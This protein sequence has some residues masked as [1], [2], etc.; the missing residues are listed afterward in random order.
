VD[1]MK[2][3]ILLLFTTLVFITLLSAKLMLDELN[4]PIQLEEDLVVD[5]LYGD[6]IYNVAE[7]LASNNVIVYRGLWVWYARIFG[8]AEKIKAGE[9]KIASGK[10]ALS[11]L[12]D[13]VKG[14]AVKYTLTIIEGWT[15][16]QAIRE[17]QKS[18]GIVATLD[19]KDQ[20]IIL[21]SINAE[22]QYSSSEG[23]FYPDTYQYTKGTKDREILQRAHDHLMV[24][25]NA[26]WERRAENLPYKN[27]YEVL[28]MASIIE[29]ES[30]VDEERKQISGVFVERLLRG[31]RLQT[32]PTV[33]YGM[34]DSYQGNI[35]RKDLV[36]PTAYN[37]YTIDGLPP[38]PISLVSRAA[39]DAA[40]NPLLNGMIFF[41][42]KGDGR[43]V[44][45][46]TL[47]DHNQ[48]V[49]EYQLSRKKN[50]RSTVAECESENC[51][52]K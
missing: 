47:I 16:A 37:T 14:N 52:E 12:D 8:M 36:T 39:L 2:Q 11:I 17:L 51:N 45:S 3:K 48:A 31:M 15:A 38:T 40:V 26:V 4:R 23:L 50:Y 1:A 18:K 42:A 29:K 7:K 19:P 43:H 20:D 27:A 32:D 33:I 22:G 25:L 21:K 10:T 46:K 34:G 30:G 41:V 49:R 24:E 44:F 6:S 35:R 5:V 13:M 9:Y 28:I